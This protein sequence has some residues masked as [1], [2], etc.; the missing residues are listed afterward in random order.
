MARARLASPPPGEP[1]PW[2]PLATARTYETRPRRLAAFLGCALVVATGCSGIPSGGPA[3]VVRRVPA[4]DAEALEPRVSRVI[5]KPAADAGPE[6]IVFGYLGA[7]AV[8]TD[9]FA[10][11]RSRLAPGVEWRPDARAVVYASRDTRVPV[12]SG[13]GRD[14]ATVAVTF[15]STGT[16]S[17]AGE[18]RPRSASVPVTFRL[19]LV[20]DIGW[21]LTEA[22]PGLLVSAA[23]VSAALQRATLYW[24]DQARRLIPAPVFLPASDRPVAAIVSALLA[25]PRGWIAPA[26]RSEIPEGTE[27]LD[28]AEI[29]DGVVTLNFS[30]EIRGASQESL[31]TLVAQV[32]WTLTERPEV[33][34]VRLLVEDSPLA[35]PGRADVREHH[36]ADWAD[37][38]PVPPTADRRLFFVR[39][40]A[41]YA[42]DEAGRLSRVV[43][44]PPLSSLA[45]NRAGTA[46]AAVTRP[47]GG[48][49]SLL[50]VDL[51]GKAAPRTVTTASRITPPTWEPGGDV[52]WAVGATG[53][54]QRIVAAR[55]AGGVSTVAAPASL[56]SPVSALRLSPNGARAAVVAGS[57]RSASL[58]LLRVERGESG[59]RALASPLRVLPS[60]RGVTAVAFDGAAQLLVASYTG[61]RPALYRLDLDGFGLVVQREAGLPGRPVTALTVS[62]GEPADRVASSDDRLWRRTPGADWAAVQGRGRAATFAG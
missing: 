25:G 60:A 23:D 51:A 26:V 36:R 13:A 53:S 29:V 44:T 38:A 1:P 52:V 8:P 50:L 55:V 31:R 12:I 40:A 35:V 47:S 17:A 30:R 43:R 24:P 28:P 18:Y 27:L 61:G 57:G 33:R 2:A 41:A 11:A 9:D 39:N 4:K 16:V 10:A 59:G 15:A 34:A 54:D 37:H 7:Q 19:R 46:L 14:R 22:P 20:P 45:V 49:Q 56:P 58:L 32:V 62:T 42:L 48:R 21:R 6:D 3:R 5:P